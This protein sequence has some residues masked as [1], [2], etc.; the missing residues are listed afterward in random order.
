MMLA[1]SPPA[2]VKASNG[3]QAARTTTVAE[4]LTPGKNGMRRRY[5]AGGLHY[6]V[7]ICCRSP[8]GKHSN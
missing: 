2:K 6:V 7:T 1:T 5:L 8:A 4:L 3:I